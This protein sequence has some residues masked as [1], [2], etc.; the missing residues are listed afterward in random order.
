L[1]VHPGNAVTF[2]MNLP[3][4]PQ[5]AGI[6]LGTQALVLDAQAPGGIGAV[7]NGGVLRIF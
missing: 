6:V 3:A 5:L 2:A 4:N 7:T 1:L